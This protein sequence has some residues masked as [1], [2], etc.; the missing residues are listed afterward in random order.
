MEFSFIML[1]ATAN[2]QIQKKNAKI[3]PENEGITIFVKNGEL[4]DETNL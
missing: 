3:P 1:N 2:L 4:G